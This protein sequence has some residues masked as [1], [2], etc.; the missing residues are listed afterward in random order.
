[1]TAAVCWAGSLRID[2][3]RAA[4]ASV[5]RSNRCRLRRRLDSTVVG[6]APNI[7]AVDLTRVGV[8]A[9]ANLIGM[10]IGAAISIQQRMQY[11]FGGHGDPSRVASDFFVG[12]GTAVAPPFSVMVILAVLAALAALR[13]KWA[14]IPVAVLCVLG[15]IGGIG[16]LG[17]PHTWKVIRPGSF[18][19]RGPCTT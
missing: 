3:A 2:A 16:F 18:T 14:T 15:L 17:E 9:I 5:G 8:A 6:A 19:D 11:E 1:V 7:G 4:T 13:G 12:S 10:T